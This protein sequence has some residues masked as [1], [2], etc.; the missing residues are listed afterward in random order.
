VKKQ[1][2]ADIPP[3]DGESQE[4]HQ[5]FLNLALNAQEAMPRGGVLTVRTFVSDSEVVCE[6]SDTGVGIPQE[7]LETIFEPFFTYRTSGDG[8]GLGLYLVRNIVQKYEGTIQVE[9]QMGVGSTFRVKFPI[10]SASP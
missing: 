9:S 3:V 6:I 5:I 1:F 7:H 4:F 10:S 8:T 2:A